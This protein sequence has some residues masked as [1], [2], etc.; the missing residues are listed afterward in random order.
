MDSEDPIEWNDMLLGLREGQRE[1]EREGREGEGEDKKAERMKDRERDRE[2]KERKRKDTNGPFPPVIQ[3]STS[4]HNFKQLKISCCVSCC[5]FTPEKLLRF[6]M[7]PL[8]FTQII[9]QVA[10]KSVMWL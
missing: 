6:R 10:A 5:T 1:R 9:C 7:K 3:S 4:A 8:Y 2:Q